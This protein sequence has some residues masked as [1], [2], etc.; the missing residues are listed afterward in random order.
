VNTSVSPLVYVLENISL[1]PTEKTYLAALF[2]FIL[3]ETLELGKIV[4]L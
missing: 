4:S 2:D 1:Y 3:I